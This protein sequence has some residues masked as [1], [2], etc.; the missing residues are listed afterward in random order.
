MSVHANMPGLSHVRSIANSQLDLVPVALLQLLCRVRV[1]KVLWHFKQVGEVPVVE[2]ALH[3]LEGVGRGCVHQAVLEHL[4]GEGW[5]SEH[6]KNEVL[7]V[8]HSEL[9]SVFF[10]ARNP[11]GFN[12]CLATPLQFPSLPSFLHSFLHFFLPSFNPS[13]F[14]PPFLPS[15]LPPSL[16]PFHPFFLPTCRL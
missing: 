14:L 3:P 8:A 6:R 9:E 10:S 1:V 15:S 13:F 16:P 2:V 4:R 12:C 7:R 5:C 11:M